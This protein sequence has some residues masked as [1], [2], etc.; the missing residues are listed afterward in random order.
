MDVDATITVLRGHPAAALLD[1]LDDAAIDLVAIATHGRTGLQRLV[2][3]SVAEKVV[4]M[5]PCPVF[6]VKSF[7]K[8]LVVSSPTKTARS[9]HPSE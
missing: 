3:G 2:M 9:V 8:S 4:R 7:G 6:T 5:A 1:M